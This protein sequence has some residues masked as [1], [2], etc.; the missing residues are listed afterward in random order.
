MSDD[1]DDFDSEKTQIFLPGKDKP[2]AAA[3]DHS[4]DREGIQLKP[5]SAQTAGKPPGKAAG[6]VDFDVSGEHPIP[7]KPATPRPAASAPKRPAPAV[8]ASSS[9]G[10]VVIVAVLLVIAAV[11]YL[12]LR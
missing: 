3:P 12:L 4:R 9:P 8:P 11:A 1:D 2:G 5:R 7:E 10:P 6:E